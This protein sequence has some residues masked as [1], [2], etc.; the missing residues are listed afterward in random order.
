M[1]VTLP[2]PGSY[3]NAVAANYLAG[4]TPKS[5]TAVSS[6]TVLDVDLDGDGSGSLVDCDD[7][8]ASTYPGAPELCDGVDNDCDGVVPANEVDGDN[9]GQ[10][11]CDGDGDDTDVNT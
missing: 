6:T 10:T 2:A 4:L 7:G 1:T 9:D 11:G 8:D 5:V 3:V